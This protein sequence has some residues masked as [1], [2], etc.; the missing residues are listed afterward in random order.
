MPGVDEG[1]GKPN[2]R[3]SVWTDS[4]K[5][6]PGATTVDITLSDA[7]GDVNWS[8]TAALERYANGSW[9]ATDLTSGS[10]YNNVS[11]SF[12][13]TDNLPGLYRVRVYL[14][15]GSYQNITYSFNIYR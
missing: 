10:F 2:L 14:S 6:G 9:T 8:Y 12:N 11:K 13:I 15:P 5:Y 3:T 7:Y 4:N 1:I